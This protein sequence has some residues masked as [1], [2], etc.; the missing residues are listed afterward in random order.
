MKNS[1]PFILIVI[2]LFA[3]FAFNGYVMNSIEYELLND[4]VD[5]QK[6]V[7]N[8][9]AVGKEYEILVEK[10]NKATV[11]LNTIIN[12]SAYNEIVKC[13]SDMGI[14][15]EFDDKKNLLSASDNLVFYFKN[16]LEGEKCKIHNIL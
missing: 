13:I 14:A 2:F 7:Y 6:K 16:I 3:M 1:I 9:E 5:I 4:A 10:M 11:K 15:I 12:H 8:N